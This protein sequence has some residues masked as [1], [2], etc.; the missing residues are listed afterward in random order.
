MRFAWAQTKARGGVGPRRATD[1]L[2]RRSIDMSRISNRTGTALS[3]KKTIQAVASQLTVNAL[4]PQAVVPNHEQVAGLAYRFWD[5]RG[6]PEGS[7]D[8]D[9]FRAE[10]HLLG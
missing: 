8:E 6:R 1:D 9:W 4:P 7:P 5:E 2:D 10:K 3:P